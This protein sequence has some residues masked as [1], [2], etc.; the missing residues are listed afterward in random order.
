MQR[1][2]RTEKS[3]GRTAGVGQQD[4]GERETA[5]DGANQGR[6]PPHEGQGTGYEGRGTGY[7]GQ[8]T[9]YE[10][11]VTGYEGRGTG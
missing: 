3:R 8:G 10:G 7:E 5:C 9:G 2:K 1:G 6:G 11:R 4:R